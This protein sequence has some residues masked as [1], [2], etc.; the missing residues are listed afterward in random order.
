MPTTPQRVRGSFY[1]ETFNRSARVGFGFTSDC[2]IF[3]I[4]IVFFV[5]CLSR[6]DKSFHIIQPHVDFSYIHNQGAHGYSSCRCYQSDMY[7]FSLFSDD[8]KVIARGTRPSSDCS[9]CNVLMAV[10][11]F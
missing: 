1:R 10:L 11:G 3:I 7:F 5:F 8:R 2:Y 4:F 6:L 9:I